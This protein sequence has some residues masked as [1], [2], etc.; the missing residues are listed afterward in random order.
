MT[1]LFVYGFALEKYKLYDLK[2]KILNNE[3][4]LWNFINQH[5]YVI[6]EDIIYTPG[7]DIPN[8]IDIAI[9]PK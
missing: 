8:W 2:E 6:T 1:K 3:L 4:W 5:K 7:E 9:I